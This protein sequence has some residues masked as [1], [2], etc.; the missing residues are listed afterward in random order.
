MT[1]G[2]WLRLARLADQLERVNRVDLVLL[3]TVLTLLLY[4]N[5]FWYLSTAF[6]DSAS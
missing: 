1:A 6:H 3:L 2:S 5:N 4:H